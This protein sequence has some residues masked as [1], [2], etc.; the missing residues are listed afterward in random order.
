MERCPNGFRRVG[1]ECVRIGKASKPKQKKLLKKQPHSF[2]IADALNPNDPYAQLNRMGNKIYDAWQGRPQ[3]P[4]WLA[5]TP[6]IG[7]ASEIAEGFVDFN[8]E[9]AKDMAN[10]EYKDVDLYNNVERERVESLGFK[11]IFSPGGFV[12]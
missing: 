7:W 11:P 10:G 6:V 2:A 8:I 1:N 9:V 12:F 4:A 5:K 3:I